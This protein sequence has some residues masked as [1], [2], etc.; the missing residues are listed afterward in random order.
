[1]YSKGLFSGLFWGLLF[2]F[3]GAGFILNTL[4]HVNIPLTEFFLAFIFIYLGLHILFGHGHKHRHDNWYG[5]HK[6]IFDPDNPLKD[7]N[8]SF[9]GGLIDLSA[10]KPSNL[11]L[12]LNIST[13]FGG[14]A[15]LLNPDLPVRISSFVSLGEVRL[16]GDRSAAFPQGKYE[17][18]DFDKDKPFLDIDVRVSFGG[19]K[20]YL[21]KEDFENNRYTYD[22]WKERKK[23]WKKHRHHD[24]Y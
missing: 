10:I 17:S 6:F 5:Y 4:F 20:F 2:I 24:R 8:F 22:H 19:L 9:G 15:V 23:E 11:P 13:S 3:I 7:I 18:K 14:G 16:P 21:S 1:M 12:S